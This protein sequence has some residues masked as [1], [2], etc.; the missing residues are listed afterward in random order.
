M[1]TLDPYAA[2]LFAAD[3]QMQA[4]AD[5][6]LG[7][8]LESLFAQLR[9]DDVLAALVLPPEDGHDVLEILGQKIVAQLPPAVRPGETLLLQVTSVS[10][11]QL[12]VRSLG[13]VDPETPLPPQLVQNAIADAPAPTPAS[14]PAAAPVAPQVRSSVAPPREVFV[15]ASVVRAPLPEVARPQIAQTVMPGHTIIEARI[16]AARATTAAPVAHPVPQ[17]P[18][19]PPVPAAVLQQRVVAPRSGTPEALLQAV[20][21]PQS[22]L[23]ISAARIASEAVRRLPEVLTRL[24]RALQPLAG[25]A[26]AATLRTLSAFVTQL[27]PRNEEALPHQIASYVSNV[28]E[29]AERKIARLI[30][31]HSTSPAPQL[32]TQ[33]KALERSAAIDHDLKSLVLSLVSRPPA[34][35]TPELAQALRDAVVTLS[36]AQLHTMHQNVQTPNALSFALPMFFH[37]GGQPARIRIQRD[38]GNG[39]PGLT[40]DNFHVALVL[41]TSSLG[42]VAVELQSAGR[43]V[44]V[45]VRTESERQVS[46]FKS[47]LAGLVTRL[48][49]LRYRVARTSAQA[50]P[51]ASPEPHHAPAARTKPSA[52]ANGLDLRA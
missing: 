51:L 19:P 15:A 7:L 16:T 17:R 40:G 27:D 38:G 10:A 32:F 42:T 23:M 50:V 12:M 28:L 36:G 47:T 49:K 34:Q 37:E 18:A 22:P 6:T 4:A 29:G 13:T 25:D 11:N 30:E 33:A 43:S 9:I 21:V 31:A 24:E 20:R 45:N 46:A 5:L 39:A 2:A 35:H 26:R 41:D 48:E 3:A 8:P 1:S 14:P 52:S 44:T